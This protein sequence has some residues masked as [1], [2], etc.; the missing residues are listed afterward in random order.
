MIKKVN[1]ASIKEGI[2][3]WNLALKHL[4]NANH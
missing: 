2:F 4:K 3:L 1:Y